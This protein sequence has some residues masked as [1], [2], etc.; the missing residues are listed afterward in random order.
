MPPV[1]RHFSQLESCLARSLEVCDVGIKLE[2]KSV[3]Y[4]DFF[5]IG[6]SSLF[7]IIGS[8]FRPV[9]FRFRPEIL[10]FYE[11]VILNQQLVYEVTMF[12]SSFSL[13]YRAEIKGFRYFCLNEAKRCTSALFIP[14]ATSLCEFSLAEFFITCSICSMHCHLRFRTKT[15]KPRAP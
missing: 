14:L 9:V 6:G 5:W 15:K 3:Q 12:M 10:H 2:L 13:V 7:C 11:K 4:H 1:W 8:C